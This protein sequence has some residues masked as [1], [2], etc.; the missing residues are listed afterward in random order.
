MISLYTG[1]RFADMGRSQVEHIVALREAHDSGMCARSDSL[2]QVFAQD[3]DNLTLA[4][5]KVNQAKGQKDAGE[6]QPP[7]NQCWFARQVVIVKHRYGLTIDP[8]EQKHLARMLATCP[9]QATQVAP[10]SWGAI[11]DR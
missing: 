9:G 5:P 7:R 3:L 11:K 2:K 10:S 8:M 4:K 1:E 6:W